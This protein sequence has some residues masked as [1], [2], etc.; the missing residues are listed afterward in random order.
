MSIFCIKTPD[1]H[2]II[3]QINKEGVPQRLMGF[4]SSAPSFHFR[5]EAGNL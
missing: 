2:V 1:E 4:E 5:A 3:L